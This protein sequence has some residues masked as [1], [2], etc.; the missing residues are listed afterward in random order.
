MAV[1][2]FCGRYGIYSCTIVIAV[3]TVGVTKVMARFTV[4]VTELQTVIAR[5]L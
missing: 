1:T 4:C 3:L 2:V 5:L